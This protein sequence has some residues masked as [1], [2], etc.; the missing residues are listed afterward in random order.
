MKN[1][2][3]RSMIEMLAVLAII[4]ILSIGG[5]AGYKIALERHH[6]NNLVTELNNYSAI[7]YGIC[8]NTLKTEGSGMTDIENCSINTPGFISFNNFTKTDFSDILYRNTVTFLGIEE[9][10]NNPDLAFVTLK[11]MTKQKRMCRHIKVTTGSNNG[12]TETQEP[13]TTNIKLFHN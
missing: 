11:V 6:T 13:Y 5:I 3:G 12:C 4:G 1:Q 10:D 8:K 9:Q 2:F 7:I